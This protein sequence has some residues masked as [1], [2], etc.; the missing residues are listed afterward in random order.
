[1]R[2][3]LIIYGC[4]DTLSGGYLYDRKLVEYLRSQGDSVEIVSLPWRNYGWHI[5]QNF[6]LEFQREILSKEVDVWL[7][8]EL[9]HPSLFLLN[10][11]IRRKLHVPLVSIVHHLR[12]SE[13]HSAAGLWLYRRVESAY[14]RSVDAF[15]YNSQTTRQVVESMLGAETRGLVATPAGDRFSGL[16]I[17]RIRLRCQQ[18][19]SL[20]L[21]FV[22]NLIPRKGLLPFIDALA[23]L[24]TEQWVL[25]VIGRTDVDVEYTRKIQAKIDQSGLGERIRLRG[26]QSD[27][28]L[29]A[30]LE[31]A[32]LLVMVSSYEG[33]G[34]VYLEGMHA[35]LPV[36]ASTG[37][38]AWEIVQ[39]GKT[40]CLVAPGD[41]KGL[42][43][44]LRSYMQD[45]VRLTSHSLEARRRF[46]TFPRW[47]ETGCAIRAFL[48]QAAGT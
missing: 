28:E 12:S 42:T 4:L 41:V 17:D 44:A 39:E 30:W 29:E 34:I 16:D 22:G 21:V 11:T 5:A 32:Q 6:K 20:R 18:P 38:A 37:G 45:R 31:K 43:Q 48:K 47:Q 25:D 7:Q 14:L 19:G 9:N 1:M 3:G 13:A 36:I 8:D 40:G 27:V 23:G 2:I 35:G 33:F 26:V 10:P 15:I 46:D 24:E